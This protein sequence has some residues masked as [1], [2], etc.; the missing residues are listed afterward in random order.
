MSD[1]MSLFYMD[2]FTFPSADGDVGVT[3]IY[4]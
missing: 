4:Y 3:D 1:Y 2:V